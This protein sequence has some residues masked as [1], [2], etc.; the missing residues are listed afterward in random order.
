MGV[1]E[2]IMEKETFRERLKSS[3]LEEAILPIF[4]FFEPFIHQESKFNES[5]DK[6]YSVES[7]LECY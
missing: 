2:I 4:D 3:E 5:E 7:V 6:N 1:I